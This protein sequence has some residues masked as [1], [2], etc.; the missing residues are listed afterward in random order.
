MSW[1]AS[2]LEKAGTPRPAGKE[3]DKA[4]PES[5]ARPYRLAGGL[6]PEE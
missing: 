1:F 6:P 5:L 3:T 2:I 4:S